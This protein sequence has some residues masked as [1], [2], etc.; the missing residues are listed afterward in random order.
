[1]A[2]VCN[3]FFPFKGTWAVT[4]PGPRLVTH[5][6]R[7]PVSLVAPKY[8]GFSEHPQQQ[9]MGRHARLR[10]LDTW[11]CIKWSKWSPP[12]HVGWHDPKKQR[13]RDNVETLWGDM[14][15]LEVFWRY[16]G[17]GAFLPKQW[18]PTFYISESS[19]AGFST[20]S[21]STDLFHQDSATETDLATTSA[22]VVE[23]N[24]EMLRLIGKTHVI[25]LLA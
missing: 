23:S 17:P 5:S 2:K 3:R 25:L 13:H 20:T 4:S 6:R 8:H 24:I 18:S 16:Y 11:M 12:C 7:H 14:N 1:M 22:E 19:L 9:A 10:H 21:E 15:I